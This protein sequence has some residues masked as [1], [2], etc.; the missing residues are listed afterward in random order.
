M[1]EDAAVAEEP[2]NSTHRV[3]IVPVML[4]PHPNA[5]SLSI[6]RIE[7][8]Q[9]IVRTDDWQESGQGA[10]VPPDSTV[11]LDRPEFAFLADPKHPE[12]DRIRIKARR[13]RGEWSMGLLVPAPPDAL[14]GDDVAARLG[15]EHYN[16]P[17]PNLKTG[18]EA[19]SP[20]RGYLGT[21]IY[22]YP[23][24]DVEAF[25]K[26]GRLAFVP[27]E[28]VYVTEKIHGTSG[29][30]MHDGER[31]YCGSRTEWKRYDENNLW[32]RAL[33]SNP[34]LGNFLHMNPG[35]AV[36]GEVYGQVQDLKYGTARG[37]YRVAVFDI[38]HQGRWVNAEDARDF[39]PNPWGPPASTL[40]W[41]PTFNAGEWTA[42]SATVYVGIPF[43]FDMLLR[44]AE[45]PS[46]IPGADHVREGIV[47]KPMTERWHPRCGRV[48]LKIIAN[49]YLE[50]A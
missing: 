28:L 43:D 31:Y 11:P 39:Q 21:R 7:G 35:T 12:K 48:N 20:P 38:L 4:E 18:G 41:V 50:R 33:V 30:W 15:V 45:G 36:Y 22:D 26:Y 24:Y 23:K 10:Y 44:L 46:L 8:Y 19:E 27:E 49:G 17:E 14:I 34:A 29:R 2:V 1:S 47:V 6:V 16:P 37:E 13:L 32:W 25:R 3:D 9:V 40:P 42:Q 5:D